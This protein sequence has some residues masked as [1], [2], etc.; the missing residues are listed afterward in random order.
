MLEGTSSKNSVDDLAVLIAEHFKK[1]DSHHMPRL[2]Y[3]VFFLKLANG[4][5]ARIFYDYRTHRFS[6][7]GLYNPG[8]GLNDKLDFA[9]TSLREVCIH[10]RG[11]SFLSLKS[12]VFVEILEF[13]HVQIS[14]GF[15]EHFG[16]IIFIIC[17]LRIIF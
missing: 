11:T 1:N 15:F 9:S 7:S 2:D 12:M 16:T 10:V 17:I 14:I 4:W 8:I 5:Y 6:F 3:K 13:P